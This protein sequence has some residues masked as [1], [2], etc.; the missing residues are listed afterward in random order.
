MFGFLYVSVAATGLIFLF[1]AQIEF[2]LA[3]GDKSTAISC[4]GFS[5]LSPVLGDSSVFGHPRVESGSAR[6]RTCF[7]GQ[8][9]R[10][11]LRCVLGR[12]GFLSGFCLALIPLLG[13]CFPSKTHRAHRKSVDAC[14]AFHCGHP[15]EAQHLLLDSIK[16]ANFCPDVLLPSHSHLGL[17]PGLTT[18]VCCLTPAASRPMQVECIAQFPALPILASSLV[19]RLLCV[20]PVLCSCCDLIDQS[21]Y[22]CCS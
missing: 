9:T 15:V 3:C 7:S 14:S 6:P 21:M 22:W 16:G 5:V 20:R 4:S 13:S 10:S 11:L 12:P 8:L 17:S 19:S 2:S 18:R 1:T